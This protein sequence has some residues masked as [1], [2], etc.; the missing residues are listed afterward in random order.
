MVLYS[1]PLSSVMCPRTVCMSSIAEAM[2]RWSRHNTRYSLGVEN[3]CL[4]YGDHGTC[5]PENLK[6]FEL[7][8]DGLEGLQGNS[9]MISGWTW[10]YWITSEVFNITQMWQFYNNISPKLSKKT[11]LKPMHLMCKLKKLLTFVILSCLI[12]VCC[13]NEL[14]VSFYERCMC[15]SFV[16]VCRIMW[17]FSKWICLQ[18]ASIKWTPCLTVWPFKVR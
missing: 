4:I 5:Q 1:N 3:V 8:L 9:S 16:I 10:T 2:I 14:G 11:R 13:C 12:K 7:E 18:T 6:L 17:W 15:L